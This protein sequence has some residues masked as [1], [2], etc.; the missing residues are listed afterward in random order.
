M[1]ILVDKAF[2]N[3]WF[4]QTYDLNLQKEQLAKLLGIAN[5]KQLFQFNGQLYEQVDGVAMDSPLGP[6]MANVFMCRLEDKLTRDGVMPALYRRYVDDTLARIPSTEAATD[7]LT[8]LN[9]LHPSLSFT[10][11]FPDNNKIPLFFGIEIIKNGTRIETHVYRKP[12]NTGL[13]LHFQ[14]LT[15]KRYKECLLKTMIHRAH[16]LSS[17]TEA[18]NEECNRLRGIFI[19]LQYPVALINSTINNFVRGISL[20]DDVKRVKDSSVVRISLPFKDQISANAVRRQ[21]KDLSNEDL[22]LNRFSSARN[23]NRISSQRK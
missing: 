19:R 16:S 12:T 6:L 8:T 14:S 7:F 5:T 23:W 2:T 15:D 1:E 10:I 9:S 13:L 11:E 21:M 20:G 4:N 22:L 3:D 18:F 17:T